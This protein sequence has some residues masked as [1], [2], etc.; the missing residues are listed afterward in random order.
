VA[1]TFY[2]IGF[3]HSSPILWSARQT[4]VAV[5]ALGDRSHRIVQ[6][7]SRKDRFLQAALFHPD[8]QKIDAWTTADLYLG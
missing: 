4:A 5:I 6:R 2:A 1:T 8:T 7:D 3:A